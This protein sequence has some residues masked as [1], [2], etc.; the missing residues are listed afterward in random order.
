MAPTVHLVRHAQGFHNL[1]MSNHN[2]PDPLLTDLGKDQCRKLQSSF[3][4][5]DKVDLV[6]ASPIK[7]TVYTALLSFASVIKSKNLKVIA[8]PELQE[9]SDLPCDTGSSVEEVEREFSG[10]PVDLSL[11]HADWNNKKGRWAPNARAIEARARD[12]RKWL[13]ERKEKHIVV[14]THGG[15]LHYFTEDWTGSNKFAGA[16][17]RLSQ[18][19]RHRQGR[20][21]ISKL[22]TGW[23]N[24]EFRTYTIQ[25]VTDKDA[26]LVETAESRRLRDAKPLSK[27]EQENLKETTQKSWGADGYEKA[28]EIEAKV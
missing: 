5:M 24:T 23:A 4:H 28:Q 10:Q 6:V 3:P 26:K 18:L 22:G 19:K 20:L 11:L 7:R 14:V 8:L 25:G 27:E 16:L 13:A 15:F 17:Y 2:M 1:S 9:T 21:L 12:A